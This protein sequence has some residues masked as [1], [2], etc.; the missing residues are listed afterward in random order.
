[1]RVEVRA[2]LTA[3]REAFHYAADL[4]AEE[5]GAETV[6]RRFDVRIPR[7]A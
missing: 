5:V 4:L 6:T 1:V 7:T 3:T 2:R